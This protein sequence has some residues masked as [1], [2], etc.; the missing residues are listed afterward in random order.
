MPTWIVTGRVVERRLR[1]RVRNCFGEDLLRANLP[2]VAE[3]PRA[4]LMMLEG[5]AL[6]AG[7]PLR[8]V[9][10]AADSAVA[11]AE[12]GVSRIETSAL[13]R[14]EWVFSKPRQRRLRLRSRRDWVDF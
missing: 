8:A 4:F 6:W 5:L 14:L 12:P 13:V 3:H 9:I 11:S 1:L 7:E 2:V 10:S